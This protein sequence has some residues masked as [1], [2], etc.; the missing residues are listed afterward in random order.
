MVDLCEFLE[1]ATADTS[2]KIIESCGDYNSALKD[3]VL[4]LDS[5]RDNLVKDWIQR[6]MRRNN[7]H[8][9]KMFEAQ[10]ASTYKFLMKCRG[11]SDCTTEF[12]K[13]AGG[14][15]QFLDKYARLLPATDPEPDEEQVG[16]L[17]VEEPPVEKLS[18]AELEICED[19]AEEEEKAAMT[20]I[21]VP[22]TEDRPAN[23]TQQPPL[24]IEQKTVI[25]KTV[26][27]VMEYDPALIENISDGQIAESIEKLKELNSQ[28]ALGG[29]DPKFVLADSDLERIYKKL[30]TY[31]PDIFKSF[32]LAYLKSVSSE[33]ER[34]RISAVMDDFLSFVRG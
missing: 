23:V 15:Q 11:L 12:V 3:F 13:E 9:I 10:P 16:E 31:P 5:S 25:N 14:V 29:L 8:C 20:P 19:S 34:F 4:V 1:V 22:H 28:I 17:P 32:V 6:N 30:C 27:S 2:E 26:E 21:E 18:A 7:D 24:I 33:T